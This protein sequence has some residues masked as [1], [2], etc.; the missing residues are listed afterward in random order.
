MKNTLKTNNNYT[1]KHPLNIA[2]IDFFFLV[3]TLPFILLYIIVDE[4]FKKIMFF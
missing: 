1:P 2:L 3:K 4:L